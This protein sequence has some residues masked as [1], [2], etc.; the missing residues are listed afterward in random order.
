MQRTL[1]AVDSETR[2]FCRSEGPFPRPVCISVAEPG[3]ELLLLGHG[4]GRNF[5]REL[6]SSDPKDYLLIGHS[7]CKF[8]LPVFGLHWPELLPLIFRWLNAGAISDIYYRERMLNLRRHGR[9]TSLKLPDG[10]SEELKYSLADLEKQY[11]GIDRSEQ[12]GEGTWRTNYRLLENTP[13]AQWPDDA[14]QYALDDASGAL[15]V[16][17]KQQENEFANFAS[18]PW[19]CRMGFA[20]ALTTATP[21]PIDPE[22]KYR[23]ALEVYEAIDPEMMELLYAAGIYSRPEMPRTYKRGAID[24]VNKLPKI[25]GGDH[26]TLKRAVLAERVKAAYEFLGE[27]PPLT[28]KGGISTNEDALAPII[29]QDKVI[30]TYHKVNYHKKIIDTELP[31]LGD[32]SYPV[33]FGFDLPQETGRTSSKASWAA[34]EKHPEGPIFSRNGQNVDPR[35]KPCFYAPAGWLLLSV[36]FSTL[37]LCSLAWRLKAMGLDSKLFDILQRGWDAHGYLGG[38]IMYNHIPWFREGI[39]PMDFDGIY[40]RFAQLRKQGEQEVRT[41]CDHYRG[42]AKPTGLGFPGGLGIRRF[43]VYAKSQYGVEV[44]EEEAKQLKKIWFLIYPEMRDYFRILERD[45]RDPRFVEA[46]TYTTPFGMVRSNCSYT[47]AA[48][49]MGLQ[50]PAAE[51]AYV[52]YYSVV[53]AMLNP[54]ANDG[55]LFGCRPVDFLHD[56]GLF[57]IPD[58]THAHD[59]TK[60]VQQLFEFGMSSVLQGVPIKTEAVLMRRWLKQAKPTFNERGMLI[61]WEDKK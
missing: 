9:L 32:G 14:K 58:D 27:M 12:K 22:R 30:D 2:E 23:V 35:V 55:L 40:G 17:Q 26:A 54:E 16:W 59:R 47:A 50:S 39:D 5:L 61:P 25:T 13:V 53:Q 36:D 56:E 49:G 37:E 24:P 29:G 48:N 60:R 20:L 33:Y 3:G 15:R 52:A 10:S 28:D 18:E 51:G 1:V 38:P 41:T 21:L 57:L 31:A 43:V 19:V 46:Y 6:L 11:L 44:T 7:L 34:T 8:D 4:D 45:M 42:L